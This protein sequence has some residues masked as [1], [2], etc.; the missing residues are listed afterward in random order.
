MISIHPE[1][2]RR[3]LVVK[4]SS[5][6]DIVHGTPCLRALRTRFPRAHITMAV[7]RCH[8]AVVR[9][10]PHLDAV[11]ETDPAAHGWVRRTRAAIQ[12]LRPHRQPRFD[13]ALD[14]QGVRRSALQV[15]LSGARWMGGRGGWR[16]GWDRVVRPDLRKH[17][18]QVCADILEALGVPV[19]TLAPE[20]F[21]SPQADQRLERLLQEADFPTRGF[22]LLNP[23]SRWRSKEWPLDRYAQLAHR[24]RDD[25]PTAIVVSGTQDR[26]GEAG[27][28]LRLLE[29]SPALS[30]VGQ[31]TLDEAICLYQRAGLMVTGDSGPMHIAAALHTPLVALFGPTLPERTGPWGNEHQL[32][33]RKRP[34]HH[35]AYRYDLQGEHIRAIDVE[36]AY[37][38]VTAVL[39]SHV[40]R[41]M[42]S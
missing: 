13:L 1:R 7:D 39:D 41:P 31:L 23:F 37:R 32:V 17:A 36:T 9:W 12:S 19:A 15:Y 10:N 6:G 3:I 33:Q 28:L 25:W 18:V 21:C 5:L 26:Q 16:P 30:L 42:K 4:L 34:R 8:A 27:H 20:V 22:V 2:I 38:A 14:L 29:P 40:V 24:L 11:I 35:H